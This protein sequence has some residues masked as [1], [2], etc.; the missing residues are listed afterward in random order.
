MRVPIQ[1]DDVLR[2]DILTADPGDGCA[3]WWLGQSGFLIKA[4]CGCVL[5]DPYLSD[6][7]TQKYAHTDKSHIRMTELAIRP[8]RL[9]MLDVVTSSHNHTD[10]LDADT[11][12][13]L[14][15]A[16]ADIKLVI[17]EANRQFVAQRL[18]CDPQWPVGL[19]DGQ[20]V[21]IGGFT[22][23]GLAAAH[24]EVTRDPLG[25][26]LYM[27]YVVEF[28]GHRVY[29]AGDGIW[30]AGLEQQ[31]A[32]FQVTLALLPINGRLPTRGVAGNLWGQE[33]AALA[34]A[35]SARLAVPCHFEMF[36]FNSETPDAFVAKCHELG[37]PYRLLR[38][39]E[40]LD[41]R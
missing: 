27:G 16:N 25:R 8:E 32:P 31:L 29:H 11:L 22:L 36:A 18:G 12:K 15:Q 19:V 35:I 10:H 23:H 34:N 24:E 17:P 20:S 26:P 39:G 6:S 13:P 21:Q 2:A 7:L 33:A 4:A 3:V 14:Q 40:R 38:C 1:Q 28:G 30:Y 41:L 9:D 5:L 37:Q